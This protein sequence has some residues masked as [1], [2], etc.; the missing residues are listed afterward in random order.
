MT[1]EV[2]PST[3]QVGIQI[4]SH[5]PA[6][7]ILWRT[8]RSV[9]S[10]SPWDATNNAFV[11]SIVRA[12]AGAQQSQAT[13]SWLRQ[14]EDPE[15]LVLT[16]KHSRIL[17]GS[18]RALIVSESDI[19]PLL[20]VTAAAWHIRH[21]LSILDESIR[22]CE[23]TAQADVELTHSV[24]GRHLPR[25]E[26]VNAMTVRVAEMRFRALEL[27][28]FSLGTALPPSGR[29]SLANLLD[30]L[31]FEDRLEAIND[32]VEM[33]QDVY[34]LA[35][36]RLSEFSFFHREYRLEVLILIVL[37]VEVAQIFGEIWFLAAR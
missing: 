31:E 21:E 15:T 7:R 9:A 36:D 26:H 19:D 13:E 12:T 28:R 2:Q 14:N 18:D 11:T 10:E 6:G 22:G 27:Q 34:E 29:R 35:N 5:A 30:E 1:E 8:D 24:S 20:A 33:L 3:T 23:R 32:A 25:V 37:I 4:G 16:Q 17:V